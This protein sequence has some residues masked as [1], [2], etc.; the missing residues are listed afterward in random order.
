MVAARLDPIARSA[1]LQ[2]MADE[3]FDVLVVG[4]GVTGA[5]AALDAAARGLTVA[6]VE[7][8]D[9][10]AG[11][12]SRSSKLVHGGLRYLEQKDFRLVREALHERRQ[13]ITTI[14]P[15][16]VRPLPFLYPLRHRVWERAYV[17][18]GV[19]LYDALAG[20]SA[21][22][23]RHRHLS[24]TAALRLAPGLRDDALTGAIRYHDAQ[25]DDARHTLAVVRTAAGLGAAVASAAR[26]TGLL[27][28]GDRVVGAQLLDTE[29]G[30]E[31]AVR[32]KVVIGAVGPWT[33]GFETMAGVP[34]PVQVRTS[35]GVHL[36]VPG[37]R[38]EA[39]SA[40]ILRTET[41]VLFVL[42]WGRDRWMIGTTDTPWALDPD[43]P[44]VSRADVDYLLGQVNT[45][46]REPL[47]PQDI[48]SS[49]A[50]LRPLVDRSGLTA[51]QLSREH[52][53]RRP[54]PGL[55]TVTGGKYTTYR[56][57]AADAVN[58]AAP[59]LL[60]AESM[61]TEG[62]ATEVAGEAV[63]DADGGAE[64]PAL[65]PSKTADLPLVGA[66]TASEVRVAAQRHPTAESVGAD[67]VQRVA[68][69]HG[70]LA[71]DVLDLVSADPSL[72]APLRMAPGYLRAE[73]VYAATHEGA[74]A[75]DD[76]LTRRTRASIEAVDRGEAAATEVADLVGD[77]LG[78]GPSRRSEEVA[79]YH[80]R[81]DAE[82]LAREEPDDVSADRVRRAVRD[83][84]LSPD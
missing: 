13:L 38:I 56:V 31:I 43:H 10:A 7:Q 8:R 35:K 9:F 21:A 53:V 18:A 83:P 69:R 34:D 11:T 48:V 79:R 50:G 63:D 40:L 67:A 14:A 33:T 77:V 49:F 5:G 37:H 41:S 36:I 39:S 82:R 75:L 22:V 29:S 72:G 59:D 62:R 3:P 16:L 78:W 25:V 27:K 84:R 64:P 23:P 24:R 44:A 17:G 58:A 4:G 28:Q 80:R 54:L 19:T 45:V 32:S 46:L 61:R 47:T 51:S 6:L 20:T 1:A 60:S 65:P 66:G 55:V 71:G 26:V 12:S 81:L 57:M 30:A 15:H 52:L 42:P 70:M 76:V 68:D 2:R 73:A 74:R